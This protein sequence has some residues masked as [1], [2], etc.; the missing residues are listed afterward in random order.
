MQLCS[1]HMM[2]SV[3]HF[4]IKCT[5]YTKVFNYL[6]CVLRVNNSVRI[7]KNFQSWYSHHFSLYPFSH[8]PY[9]QWSNYFYLE[10]T[11]IWILCNQ[12]ITHSLRIDDRWLGFRCKKWLIKERGDEHLPKTSVSCVGGLGTKLL[13]SCV[14]SQVT[15]SRPQPPC[16]QPAINSF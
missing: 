12:K 15:S 6:Y 14:F 11:R 16:N 7:I 1:V 13:S 5:I 2:Q 8:L 4:Q 3:S 9:N 10:I